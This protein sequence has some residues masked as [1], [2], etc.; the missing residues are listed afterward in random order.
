MLDY[1]DAFEKLSHLDLRNNQDREIIHV[2]TYC[3]LQEKI[4]NPY[5]AFIVSKFSTTDRKLMLALQYNLWDRLKDLKEL[6]KSSK[7]KSRTT[8]CSFNQ[9]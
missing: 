4:F 3:C 1:L 8:C 6:D 2:C 5:Y 7:E 9:R